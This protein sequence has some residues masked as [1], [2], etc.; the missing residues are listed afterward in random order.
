MKNDLNNMMCLD[1]YLSS[2]DED[3]YQETT[4]LINPTKAQNINLLSW[5]IQDLFTDNTLVYDLKNIHKLATNFNWKNNLNS[6]LKENSYE[7]L[8]ITNSD[9]KIIWVNN[10]FKKMTGYENEFAL[11]KSPVFLQGEKT[12]EISKEKIRKKLLKNKPFKEVI[13]NYRK[14]KSTYKCELKIFPLYSTTE[15][16]HFLALE[17]EVV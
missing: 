3:K 8:V 4:S 17:K 15:T 14:D 1:T 5:G 2:L 10:G 11:G 7:S 6:I 16:T 12:T 13:I 9:K